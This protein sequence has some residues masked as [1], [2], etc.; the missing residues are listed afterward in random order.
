MLRRV[1]WSVHI[2]HLYVHMYKVTIRYSAVDFVSF[3]CVQ[4]VKEV[5]KR[6]ENGPSIQYYMEYEA[7]DIDL[8]CYCEANNTD[9]FTYCETITWHVVDSSK[10]LQVHMNYSV[11]SMQNEQTFV[12]YDNLRGGRTRLRNQPIISFN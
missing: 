2:M 12:R 7:E 9:I 3:L 4:R 1:L 10:P 11:T 5:Y 8:S 6:L